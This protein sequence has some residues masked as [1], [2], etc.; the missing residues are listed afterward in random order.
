MS[1]QQQQT[2]THASR[3]MEFALEGERRCRAGDT[4]TG[5]LFVVIQ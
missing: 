5:Q 4:R 1:T 2:T 3:C